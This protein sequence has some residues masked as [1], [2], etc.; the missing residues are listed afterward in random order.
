MA[1]EHYWPVW[2]TDTGE[3]PAV[4][5]TEV[6]PAPQVIEPAGAEAYD[7]E[8]DPELVGELLDGEHVAAEPDTPSSRFRHGL[9]KAM[10]ITGVGLTV[11][12]LLYVGDLMF[13]AGDVPR[14]V[15]VAGIEV[16]GLSQKDAESKLRRELE[17]RL[18]QPVLVRA[19]DVET[20][21]DP[22]NSGLGLD[23]PTTLEKAGHQ[24]LS[25]IT[26][27]MS[28]FTKREVGVETRTDDKVLA[29]SVAELTHTQLDHPPTEGGIAFDPIPGSD[30]GV[31]A[32][33]V[34]PRQGQA[35]GDSNVAA[36]LVHQHWLDRGGVQVPVSTTPV[37]ASSAGVH[38][39]LEQIVNP[40]VAKPIMVHGE[41]KDVALK[42]DAIASSFL[43]APLD[44][45]DLEVRVDQSKLQ[46]GLQPELA[47]TEQDSKDASLVFVGDV[48]TVQPSE[49]GRKID[50]LGTFKPFMGVLTQPESRD[51]KVAY[52]TKKPN[53]TTDAVNA[54]GVKEVV[55]QFT[56]GGFSPEVAGNVR[57]AA[58]AVNGVVLKPGETFSLNAHLGARSGYA[59]APMNEDGTGPQVAA[60]G[61]SQLTS[62]LY[63]AA[64][65]AGLGDAGHTAHSTYLDR[66][67]PG[68]DATSFS[69]SG[70]AVDLKFTNDSPSGVAIQASATGSTV[71]VKLWSTKRYTVDSATGDRSNLAPPPIQPGSGPG[72]VPNEG[73]AGFT[74][75]DTRILRD[76]ASGAEVRRETSVVTYQPR[77][78]VI[79]T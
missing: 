76:A 11:F 16:G 67:P 31:T 24:P 77:P 23:W 60:G 10:M 41:G 3:H 70:S 74:T 38:K 52:Q 48:P 28:F 6:L 13:S 15:T 71:T 26:R 47:G 42:P 2:D 59:T 27:I 55:G 43:F 40:A 39:A 64:Y 44:N 37:K 53:L 17:P 33:A 72:C 46:Q 8:D 79:C 69:D 25:P 34:E 20:K 54:L 12:V 29:S 62:T 66:Y 51:L 9:G 78:L 68:R 49:D 21:L 7:D 50:W 18:T 35:V 65:F 75:S 45:G 1:D 22:K 58:A 4:Q 19:G 32:R 73:K 57:A 61:I 36:D 63:N 14:G 30:G 56:T 5:D